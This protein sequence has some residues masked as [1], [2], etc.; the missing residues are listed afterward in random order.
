MGGGFGGGACVLTTCTFNP[1]KNLHVSYDRLNPA[2]IPQRVGALGWGVGGWGH[3]WIW[4]G[5]PV[6]T[7]YTPSARGLGGIF[8]TAMNV[9]ITITISIEAP[10]PRSAK[11]VS[12]ARE[13]GVGSG[14][15]DRRARWAKEQEIDS[16]GCRSFQ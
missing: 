13:F 5:E 1:R 15:S 10:V 7:T 4:R 2:A 16:G 9:N 12:A 6:L 14:S 8:P 3:W 11:T